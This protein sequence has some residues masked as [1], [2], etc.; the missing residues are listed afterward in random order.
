VGHFGL[1]CSGYLHFTSPIRR[2]PDLVI[3]RL[4][5][6]ALK[7]QGL[8]GKD[9]AREVKYL[10]QI[11]PEVSDKEQQTDS[12]M[13]EASKLKMA[14]YMAGHIGKEFEAVV[15]SIFPY[16]MF[17]EVLDPPVDGLVRTPETVDLSNRKSKR[18][19]ARKQGPAIGQI[20]PVKLI[21]ADRTNGQLEFA[22]A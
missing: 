13:M 19:R 21:R 3:H 2:Y 4:V 22:F 5:K 17:I 7:S 15:T 11:S 14:A 10:K 9:Q 1:A 16:G 8:T 20:V 6:M 18:S 12:A